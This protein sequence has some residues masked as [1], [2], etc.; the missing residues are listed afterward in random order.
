MSLF[1]SRL[2]AESRTAQIVL[3]K[4]QEGFD[5]DVSR[6][7]L[8]AATKRQYGKR[9]WQLP[10]MA[11]LF[12]IVC[13][14]TQLP[15]GLLTCDFPMH[16]APPHLP[17]DNNFPPVEPQQRRPRSN[18]MRKGL[19]GRFYRLGRSRPAECQHSEGAGRGHETGWLDPSELY[20]R[21]EPTGDRYGS[22]LRT[23]QWFADWVLS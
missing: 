4:L 18:M 5:P 1:Q 14:V 7:R 15:T 8:Q 22:L 16:A 3:T 6:L 9:F 12:G 21:V 10:P 11:I 23:Q 17:A 2:A 19:A 13:A 20:R